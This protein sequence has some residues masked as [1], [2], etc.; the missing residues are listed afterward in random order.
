M[1]RCRDWLAERLAGATLWQVL[2]LVILLMGVNSAIRLSVMLRR[3]RSFRVGLLLMLAL[4]LITESPLRTTYAVFTGEA[5]NSAT[6]STATLTAPG[7]LAALVA[8]HD[9]QLSW[10]AGQN[11]NGYTIL[12]VANGDS[13]LCPASSSSSYLTTGSTS[14]TSYTDANR[15]APEGSSPQGTWYCYQVRTNYATWTSVQ[16]NP[17]VAAQIGFVA[18]SLRLVDGGTTGELETGDQIVFTFNQPVNPSTGPQSSDS[19]CVDSASHI[20]LGSTSV[21]GN[22]SPAAAIHLGTLSGGAITNTNT[23]FAAVYSWGN[24]NQT[25]TVTLGTRSWGLANPLFDP[26]VW[27]FTPATDTARLLSAAGNRHICDT[28]TGGGNC[29]PKTSLTQPLSVSR[30]APAKP[31]STATRTATPM[32]TATATRTA[33]PRSTVT[34]T[35][36]PPATA[37]LTSTPTATATPSPAPTMTPSRVVSATPTAT[38]PTPSVTPTPAPSAT[39]APMPSATLTP[40]PAATA[41]PA[42]SSTPI[43]IYTPATLPTTTPASTV[44]R[45]TATPTA[46]CHSVTPIATA[47]PPAAGTTGACATVTPIPTATILPSPTGTKAATQ[48]TPTASPALTPP[49][50]H[51][52]QKQS[53]PVASPSVDPGN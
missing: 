43:A 17:V 18:S 32:P 40:A 2:L 11:G 28:N 22:C 31:A 38:A 23:G 13:S 6:F 20:L 42:I 4:V 35:P 39:P 37:T 8:G 14:A 47:T 52:A 16:N 29:L 34:S 36:K 46:R 25:L 19:V 51:A 45:A 44:V 50:T 41:T 48:P 3:S 15:A 53:T 12:G 26:A 7:S 30:S 21:A 1:G 10:T 5:G 33:T 24:G 49:A 9:V 27:T